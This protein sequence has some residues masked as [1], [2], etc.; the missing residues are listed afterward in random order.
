MYFIYG[1][2]SLMDNTVIEEEKKLLVL[3]V[4]S[5]RLNV[6]YILYC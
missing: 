4:N 2:Y 6:F 5:I 3:L 1:Q